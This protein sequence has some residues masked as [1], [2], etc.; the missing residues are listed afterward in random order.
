MSHRN[1]NPLLSILEINETVLSI[2]RAAKIKSTGPSSMFPKIER[3]ISVKIVFDLVDLKSEFMVTVTNKS[4][5]SSPTDQNNR[6]EFYLDRFTCGKDPV[7]FF[8]SSSRDPS[9][10]FISAFQDFSFSGT[11]DKIFDCSEK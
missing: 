8:V 5:L 11:E 10:S 9:P 6:F 7:S 3:F 4:I 1:F 2:K